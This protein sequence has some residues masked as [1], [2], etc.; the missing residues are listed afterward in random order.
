VYDISRD[1]RLRCG[2]RLGVVGYVRFFQVV[3][4]GVGG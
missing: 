4:G 2:S 1:I 3:G